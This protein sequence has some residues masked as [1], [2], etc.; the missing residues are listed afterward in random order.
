VNE[1][2]LYIGFALALGFVLGYFLKKMTSTGAVDQ[3]ELLRLAASEKELLGHKAALNADLINANRSVDA[4]KQRLD[5]ENEA[6]KAL[7]SKSSGLETVNAFQEKQ[8]AEQTNQLKELND[9]LKLEFENLAN[10]ILKQTANDFSVSNQKQIG[11]LLLPL[12]ERIAGF[13]KR[14][15]EVHTSDSKDRSE[16]LSTVKSL[17]E[18]NHQLKVEANNLTN[19]L[20]GDTRQQG[21]WGEFILEKIL[22]SSGLEK[23]LEYETQVTTKDEDGIFR[24][25]VIVNLPDSKYIIIDSKVSLKAFESYISSEDID[26]QKTFLAQHVAS[27]KQH[28]KSLSSK[29]YHHKFEGQSL[30]FVLMF[31]PVEAGFS[32]ALKAD[33]SLYNF[34][35]DHKIVIVSPTTLL[36]T[37]R[38][39]S[40][41]WKQEKQNRNVFQ[42][43]EESGKLYD[44][45]VGFLSDLEKIKRGLDSS[46]D[47]YESAHN[48]L[49]SGN[50][51][52]IKRAEKIKELG[53][54][55]TKTIDQNLIE[56]ND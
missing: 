42:I 56:D 53:A 17:M 15:N 37:L 55:T 29:S 34:A 28:V 46:F 25:D 35:W 9:R 52:L 4:L 7:L 13:E 30:D 22:E 23:G 38:T 39:I 49:K 50:G 43:A 3:N 32:E 44:K 19:A 5:S 6:Y 26:A 18:L 54:K 51:N 10:Q 27:V 20:K 21:A 47:A 8:L 11:E 33:R 31:M 48:K 1:L 36:A 2:L 16:L 41:V 14:V 40:S 12:K 24:P 45:F